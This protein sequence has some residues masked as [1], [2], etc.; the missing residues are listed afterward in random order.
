MDCMVHGV[1]E[2]DMTEWLFQEN[3]Q[4]VQENCGPKGGKLK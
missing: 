4:K 2:L 3:L 1:T